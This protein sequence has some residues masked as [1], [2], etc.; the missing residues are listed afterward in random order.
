MRSLVTLVKNYFLTVEEDDALF[1]ITCQGCNVFVT[2]KGRR[3]ELL[4]INFLHSEL[5]TLVL[6]P[7]ELDTKNFFFW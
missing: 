3:G 1:K 4:K 5:S 7:E 2:F 6:Y